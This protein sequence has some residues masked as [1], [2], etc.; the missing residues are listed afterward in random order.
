MKI[1]LYFD[2]FHIPLSTSYL[3]FLFIDEMAKFDYIIDLFIPDGK[4][5]QE[6]NVDCYLN[7]TYISDN[8]YTV[9]WS[10]PNVDNYDVLIVSHNWV[11]TWSGTVDKR[12]PISLPFIK[13]KKTVISLKFDTSMEHRFLFDDVLYGTNS[14]IRLKL[15]KRMVLPLNVPTFI[16]PSLNL[17]TPKPNSLSKHDFYT[18]YKLNPELKLVTFF[19]G[20]IDKWDKPHLLYT[21]P[22]Y[23]FLKHY[24]KRIVPLFY[25]NNF[26]IIFKLHRNNSTI[27]SKIHKKLNTINIIDPVDT[28]E[29]VTYSEYALTFATSMIYE[30]YLYNLPTLDI[31]NGIY[32]PGWIHHY[33]INNANP[34][35]L[36]NT[37]WAEYNG[38]KDLIFGNTTTY[39][40]L[41]KNTNKLFND[42]LNTTY[43]INK[44]KYLHNNPIYGN[45]YSDNI[46]TIAQSL[47][48]QLNIIKNKT[49]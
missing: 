26:Q 17:S 29:T 21:R 25:K 14:L 24:T 2:P 37:K 18:K 36:N 40:I 5:N 31:S 45:S 39:K 32:H 42:F 34:D 16:F 46:N 7:H 44:F 3:I 11:K 15:N 38:C 43:D 41:R 20:R 9:N 27:S 22:I 30:L 49:Y 1:A 47:T 10:V 48:T 12:I 6:T 13:Q 23:W 19:L 35:T 33:S 4:P 28:Y 8:N